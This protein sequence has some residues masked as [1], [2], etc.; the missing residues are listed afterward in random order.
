ME[1]ILK[2][3]STIP[4][5]LYVKRKADKQLEQIIEDMERP[6]YVLVARQMGKTNLL[7][8][9][10]RELKGADRLF[11]Y[12]D[13][14]NNF[15]EER[16]CYRNIID[17]ILEPNEHLFNELIPEIFKNRQTTNLPPHKEY[18]QELRQVL[19]IFKGNLIIIMDEIDALRSVS[20]SDHIFAQIRSNYFARTNFPEFNNLTYVL[21][22]VIEP[23]DLIKDKNKSPFNIGE[24]IYLDDFTLE[25]HFEFIN[26]GQLKID[27]DISKEIFS[28]TNGN[29]RLTFDICSEIEDVVLSGDVITSNSLANLISKKYLIQYDIA[30]IDHIRDIVAKNR[31]VRKAVINI[32]KGRGIDSLEIKRKLYLYGII[33]SNIDAERVEIKNKIIK[34]SLSLEW[35]ESI[36]RQNQDL[37]S[38]GLEKIDSQEWNEA[39]SVLEE[40]LSNSEVAP[41]NQQIASY[42]IGFAYYKLG[43]L[44]G[45]INSF[46]KHPF[47]KDSTKHH[48]FYYGSLAM[49]GVCNISLGNHEEGVRSLTQ[50]IDEFSEGFPYNTAL[51]NLA[52]YYYKQN[53]LSLALEL[54]EKLLNSVSVEET[55]DNFKLRVLGNTLKAQA[56]VRQE[57]LLDAVNVIENALQS[58]D[59]SD[60]LELLYFKYSIQSE[61]DDSLLVEIARTIIDQNILFNEFDGYDISFNEVNLYQYL[62]AL[63]SAGK[64]ELFEELLEYTLTSLFKKTKGR[65]DLIVSL[66]DKSR[67][68]D[69]KLKFLFQ[70]IDINDNSDTE[71]LLDVYREILLYEKTK[72]SQYEDHFQKY[73]VLFKGTKSALEIQDITVC[74]YAIK[75][76]SDQ[77]QFDYALHVAHCIETKFV[78]LPEDIEYQTI[79]IYYWF[80]N[81]YFSKKDLSRAVLYC[82]KTL[83]LIENN[84]PSTGSLLDERGIKLISDQVKQ[85]KSSSKIR[86]PIRND[87]KFGRNDFVRVRFTDGSTKDG[88]YKKF[89]ADIIGER[90]VVVE[91]VDTNTHTLDPKKF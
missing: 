4:Q 33:D 24:K 48:L 15:Q 53:E 56:F 21:S 90:C 36:E 80:S 81:L 65:I 75:L 54:I 68:N 66:A 28:W 83:M 26:R 38:L 47:K 10:M 57:K 67:S 17:N 5:H 23:T 42:N 45:A 69:Q 63:D 78:N 43:N 9:A 85:I 11:A 70:I 50:V 27:S 3:Y 12:V 30:P 31:T 52:S 61:A 84:R 41:I 82:D 29:P 91:I 8:N 13:L 55:D 74:A 59:D 1:K 25:E 6:G 86:V 16:D 89:E 39:I 18:T 88:K 73:F 32:Q 35:L 58:A 77:F 60:K 37:F 46:T 22:G 62:L 14:S 34:R 20:Y 2:K 71:L 76:Y 79:I 51:L 72:D 7:L 19:K 44:V 87:K 49:S 64:N 40:Y